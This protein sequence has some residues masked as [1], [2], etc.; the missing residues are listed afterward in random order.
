MV[1]VAHAS[2]KLVAVLLPQPLA[3][4]TTNFSSSFD[5]FPGIVWK[6]F[7]FVSS[8][9]FFFLNLG[10]K[11]KKLVICVHPWVGLSTWVWCLWRPEERITYPGMGVAGGCKLSAPNHWAIS[12]YPQLFSSHKNYIAIAVDGQGLEPL[13]SSLFFSFSLF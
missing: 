2:L 10:F 11:K 4:Q 3:A 6:G 8:I 9:F 1:S 7:H 5:F 12:Q 13:V